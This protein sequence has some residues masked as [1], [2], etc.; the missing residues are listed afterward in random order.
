MLSCISFNGDSIT[1]I[2]DPDFIV[3]LMAGLHHHKILKKLR[4]LNFVDTGEKLSIV[5]AHKR[6]ALI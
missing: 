5:T 4:K 3:I 1:S 2:I 6:S